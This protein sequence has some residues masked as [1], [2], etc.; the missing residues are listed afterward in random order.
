M[1][2]VNR[3][4]Q[5]EIMKSREKIFKAY[6]LM[7]DEKIFILNAELSRIRSGQEKQKMSDL[8]SGGMSGGLIRSVMKKFHKE[9]DE[10]GQ[11]D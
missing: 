7:P 6:A 11:E 1:A 2:L 9:D 5:E 8:M 10:N 4:R 3:E